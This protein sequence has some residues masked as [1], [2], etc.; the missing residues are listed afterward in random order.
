MASARFFTSP[1]KIEGVTIGH[2]AT[3]RLARVESA[4]SPQPTQTSEN[5]DLSFGKL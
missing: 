4:G 5:M 1:P 3:R 2:N